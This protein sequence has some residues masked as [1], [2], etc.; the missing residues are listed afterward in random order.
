MPFLNPKQKY[1]LSRVCDTFVCALEAEK[2][3]DERLFGIRASDLNVGERMEAKLEAVADEQGRQLIKTFLDVLEIP[4]LNFLL[5][6]R[7]GRF[8]GMKVEGR[9][10]VLRSWGNSHIPLRRLIFQSLKRLS[11]FLFYAAMP[12][13]KPNP[14]WPIFA[15]DGPTAVP[16][17][18]LPRTII[19][20][21]INQATT[22]ETAVL[23]IGSGAGGGVVAGELAAAGLEVLV[24][25]KGGYYAEADYKGQEI[26]GYNALYEKE[27]ALVTADVSMSVLAG[28]ALGGGT[29]VN[30]MTC[31]TPP[32]YVLAEWAEMGFTA[33]STPQFQASLQA[34]TTRLQINTDESQPNCQNAL[35]AQGAQALGYRAE[36]IPRNAKGCVDCSCCNYGCIFGAK[37]GILKTYLQDACE[38]GAR[39]IVQA[40]VDRILQQN[41]RVTG[42]EATVSHNGQRHPL[43]IKANV[44]VVAAGA[45]HTP[46][47]L[48]R[49][50]LTNK[51]IGR[52]LHLHPVTQTWGIYDEPVFSWQGAPQTRVIQDFANLDGRGYGV[53]L[54]TSPMHPGSYASSLPWQSG[55]QHKRLVQQLHHLANHIVLTRDYHDGRIRLDKHGQPIL[56]YRLHPYDAQHLRRG[57]ME[58]FKIH[59]AAGAKTIIAPHNRYLTWQPGEDFAAFLARVERAGF[60]SNGYALFSAHQ[61]STCRLAASPAQGA[62]K[63]TGETYEVANLW[64]ADGSVFPTA[65]GVNPML[66]I[67]AV[68]HTIARHIKASN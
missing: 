40:H 49:S 21:Y 44:V 35:L 24:L 9:T 60:P 51:H 54:E 53:R 63:P 34:I 46:A 28:S 37:Q 14:T 64:V 13:G 43:T 67:M 18:P 66:T 22:L 10:A 25:E 26:A 1:T 36:V 52:H 15:Y 59:R 5:A 47:L 45:I 7:W 23:I 6:G 8:S 11:L 65:V 30:W 62:L 17:T 48:K 50:G 61:M 58:S 29:A 27:G 55:R 19:P 20:L 3:E 39:V 33:A 56:D 68:A 31:L 4:V 12:D 16:K 57:M 42:A 41:G 32:E 2:G 38:Q